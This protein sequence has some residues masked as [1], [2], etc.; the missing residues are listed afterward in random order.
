MVS[1][2]ATGFGLSAQVVGVAGTEPCVRPHGDKH[3]T[4]QG[5]RPGG[6][7]GD[8]PA[9][10]G[11]ALDGGQ[12]PKVPAVSVRTRPTVMARMP[13]ASRTPEPSL[14]MQLR[15]PLLPVPGLDPQTGLGRPLPGPRPAGRLPRS[16]SRSA[17]QPGPSRA[18]LL[19]RPGG[20]ERPRQGLV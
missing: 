3:G 7:A 15:H 10:H 13:S 11:S 2:L 9:H 12:R 8:R 18:G 19:E 17:T 20:D 6:Q 5:E 14:Q 16:K 1:R 4:E